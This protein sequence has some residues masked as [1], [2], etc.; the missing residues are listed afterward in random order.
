M[1]EV[2]SCYLMSSM[3]RNRGENHLAYYIS[4]ININIDM[5]SIYVRAHSQM[6]ITSNKKEEQALTELHCK[7]HTHSIAMAAAA[8]FQYLPISECVVAHIYMSVYCQSFNVYAVWGR[9]R[10]RERF[11]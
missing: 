7:Q 5:A 2:A 10:K 3:S 8:A 9:E 4:T 1:L 6:K 11:N